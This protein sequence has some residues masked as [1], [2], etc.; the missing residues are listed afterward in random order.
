MLTKTTKNFLI[1]SLNSNTNSNSISILKNFSFLSTSLKFKTSYFSRMNLKEKHSKANKEK[2][3]QSKTNNKIQETIEEKFKKINETKNVNVSE[4]NKEWGSPIIALEDM[5]KQPKRADIEILQLTIG[6]NVDVRK[7]DQ[8]VRGIFKMPGG[9]IRNTKVIAF[10]PPEL[11]DKALGA[12]ADLIGSIET[13]KEIQNGNID[14]DKCVCTIDMLPM[15][16]SVG[17][18]LGPQGLMPNA[19]VG[20]ACT[21]DKIESIIKDLKQ[22]SKEFKVDQRGQ[23]IVP[24]GRRDFANEK[25]L[26]NIDSFMKVLIEK[27]PDTIKGRYFLYSFLSSR[28]LSYK[29]DM[30]TLDPKT[31]TYFMNEK[32]PGKNKKKS[33]EGENVNVNVDLDLNLKNEEKINIENEN[34]QNIITDNIA[35]NSIK[36]K[37][38]I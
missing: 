17:R 16:K 27:K 36:E 8:N 19:K 4:K 25:I 34:N 31:N 28:R 35:L 21:H 10:V 23:I 18:I 29:I 32:I 1:N 26:E 30:K 9:A 13:I 11:T 24:V 12:G 7:G 3:L 37:L 20:T 15:L 38:N 14:F 33:N 6:L 5:N 22:G 2:K